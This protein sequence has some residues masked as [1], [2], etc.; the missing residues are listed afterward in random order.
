MK[1]REQG[2][3]PLKIRWLFLTLLALMVWRTVCGSLRDEWLIAACTSRLPERVDGAP[4]CGTDE[5]HR[6]PPES[7]ATGDAFHRQHKP[8]GLAEPSGE[9]NLCGITQHRRG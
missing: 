7:P 8:D 4:A 9:S 6:I 1:V 3:G 2:P 5:G